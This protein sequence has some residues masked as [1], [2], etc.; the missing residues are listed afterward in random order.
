MADLNNQRNNNNTS[1]REK[2]KLDI[3]YSENAKY[4]KIFLLKKQE[5]TVISLM[6]KNTFVS[7][8]K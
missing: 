6:F 2:L 7:I 4:N 8:I 1:F 5:I 3:N